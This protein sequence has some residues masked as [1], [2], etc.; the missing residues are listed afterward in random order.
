MVTSLPDMQVEHDG[1]FKGCTLGKNSK[2]I[3][4]SSENKSKGILE[5]IHSYV[6]GKMMVPSW[7]NLMYYVIFIDDYSRKTWIY[8]LKA[9]DEVFNEFQELK[10]LVEN[11]FGR[12]IKILRPD[13]G[14]EYK[15]NEFKYF[16]REEGIKG[17]MTNP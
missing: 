9:K 15:S 3:F 2:G 16:R 5:I 6:C 11:L 14:G 7:G 4:S 1:V 12:K 17:E 13:N 8:F 10:A